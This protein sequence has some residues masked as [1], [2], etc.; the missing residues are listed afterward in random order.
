MLVARDAAPSAVFAAVAEEVGH[1]LPEA[2]FTM[3]G[4]YV[5]SCASVRCQIPR[6][7]PGRPVTPGTWRSPARARFV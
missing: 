6:M 2:D 1:A 7:L 3:V 5:R 4:R